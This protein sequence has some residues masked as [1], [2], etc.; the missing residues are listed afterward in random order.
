MKKKNFTL[1]ELLVVIAIISILA[2]MLLPALNK[3]REK[4]KGINCLNNLKQIGFINISYTDDWDGCVPP[5][6]NLAGKTWTRIL[7]D[8]GYMKYYKAG[9]G[10]R[11][12]FTCPSYGSDSYYE[13]QS[14]VEEVTYGMGIDLDMDYSACW[15]IVSPK[16][17]IVNESTPQWIGRNNKYSPSEFLLFAD[18]ARLGMTF[19]FQWYYINER[20]NS[21][22]CK[23]LHLRHSNKAN[24]VFADGHAES[25]EGGRAVVLGYPHYKT[26]KGC[27][28]IGIYY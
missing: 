25:I 27:N 6:K 28:E 5:R 10:G 15:R 3:A 21:A 17:I 12:F 23:V 18:S 1:I 9:Q 22:A 19:Q 16:V 2:S 7:T 4:A 20:S 8:N 11:P 26:Q 14:Q 13:I 24:S